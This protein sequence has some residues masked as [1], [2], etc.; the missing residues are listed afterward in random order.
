MQAQNMSLHMGL[1]PGSVWAVGAGKRSLPSVGENVL[2]Q[3]LVPVA[4]TE[5]L[6]A[7][8]TRGNPL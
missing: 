3:V 6:A 4:A 1:L 2:L 7:R 5:R 8:S